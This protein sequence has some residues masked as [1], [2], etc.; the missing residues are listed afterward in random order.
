MNTITYWAVPSQSTHL[1]QFMGGG[2]GQVSIW[3]LISLTRLQASAWGTESRKAFNPCP[4]V[5]IDIPT[6]SDR[7]GPLKR[8]SPFLIIASVVK[9]LSLTIAPLANHGLSLFINLRLHARGLV[10]IVLEVTKR[11]CRVSAQQAQRPRTWRKTT[12]AQ[13]GASSASAAP[14]PAPAAAHTRPLPPPPRPLHCR[15]ARA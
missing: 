12:P 6:S 4:N 5:L 3:T 7:P 10:I 2:V 8:S 15:P 14:C 11:A 13:T 9:S 1:P